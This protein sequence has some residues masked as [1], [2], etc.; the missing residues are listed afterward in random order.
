M[1]AS[2]GLL[3]NAEDLELATPQSPGYKFP[4]PKLPLPPHSHLKARYHPVLDQLT[5]LMMRDGKKS[6][7]QRVRSAGHDIHTGLWGVK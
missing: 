6:Q 5:N 1:L 3:A 2:G 4:L 7:A